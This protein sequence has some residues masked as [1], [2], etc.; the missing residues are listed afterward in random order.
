MTMKTTK[1]G[2]IIALTVALGLFTP[3]LSS[4]RDLYLLSWKGTKYTTSDSGRIIAT[5]YSERDIIAKCAADNGISD[6]RSLA[7]VYVANEMDTEVVFAA[8]GETVCE[9]FQLENSFTAVPSSDGSQTVRQAFLFNEAHG[10]A[11][12]SA[13]GI[14]KAKRNTDG[15]LTTYG[16]KGTFQ[17]SIPEENAV[18][19]GTFTTGKRIKDTASQ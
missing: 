6:V 8:T 9:V 1:L 4:A 11:L 17:F 15:A 7:Y 18:Y 12:G 10:E 2:K 19:S 5:R 14:E 13:F 16:Y 3:L